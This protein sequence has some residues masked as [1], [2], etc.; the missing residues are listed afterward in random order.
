MCLIS[1][2]TDAAK[3]CNDDIY[4]YKVLIKDREF[5]KSPF[6]GYCFLKGEL[7][8]DKAETKIAYMFSRLFVE[9]GFFHMYKGKNQATVLLQRC[10]KHGIK[11]SI[12]K[13]LIPKNT[14]YYEGEDNDICSKAI[15]IL[16]EC[17]D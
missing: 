3:V 15:K 14:I 13:V 2:E 12:Y 5:L 8:Y 6:M 16:E 17:V 9:S 10:L 7:T 1:K 4:C 11:A